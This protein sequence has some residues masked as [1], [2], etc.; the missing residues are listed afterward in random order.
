MGGY[1]IRRA[2]RQI[3]VLAGHGAE[4]TA[5]PSLYGRVYNFSK[6]AM[7]IDKQWNDK[8]SHLCALD[9]IKICRLRLEAD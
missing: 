2:D 7:L 5:L 4:M 8:A 6:F 1:F 3:P 9:R